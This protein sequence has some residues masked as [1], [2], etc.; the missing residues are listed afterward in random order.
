MK[1]WRFGAHREENT[2]PTIFRI[3]IAVRALPKDFPSMRRFLLM[4]RARGLNPY[5]PDEIAPQA[6]WLSENGIEAEFIEREMEWH[7]SCD[8]DAVAFKLRFGL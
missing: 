2:R 5:V 4:V 6:E 1:F 3:M 7:F 8:E